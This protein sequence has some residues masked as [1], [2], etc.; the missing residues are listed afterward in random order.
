MPTL[1]GAR[2]SRLAQILA[3]GYLLPTSARQLPLTVC[4]RADLSEI[5]FLTDVEHGRG[6]KPSNDSR[7]GAATCA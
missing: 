3:G 5:R 7:H 1:Y 6:F 4:I 2:Q